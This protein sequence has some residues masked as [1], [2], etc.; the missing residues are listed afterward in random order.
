VLPNAMLKE[1]E[2]NVWQ[3][4]ALTTLT[5]NHNTP[6]LFYYARTTRKYTVLLLCYPRVTLYY[7]GS[8]LLQHCTAKLDCTNTHACQ[9][10]LEI[11]SSTQYT[12]ILNCTAPLQ[13]LQHVPA[14]M[15]PPGSQ[16][17][18]TLTCRPQSYLSAWSTVDCMCASAA[19]C[20]H[21]FLPVLQMQSA[22]IVRAC[23]SPSGILIA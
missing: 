1:Q 8:V 23:Y 9:C 10:G 17:H 22:A 16:Q 14:L 15:W 3:C 6:R 18:S 12:P 21:T 11:A 4:G 2:G 13:F 20:L 19:Q 5:H 7:Y